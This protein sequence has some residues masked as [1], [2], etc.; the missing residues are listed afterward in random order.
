MSLLCINNNAFIIQSDWMNESL[1]YY[2]WQFQLAEMDAL[3]CINGKCLDVI[4]CGERNRHQGPDFLHAKIRYDNALWVGQVEMH[5]LSSDWFKHRHQH[6]ANYNNVILHVVWEHDV[7]DGFSFPTLELKPVVADSMLQLYRSLMSRQGFIAC[8]S[9]HTVVDSIIAKKWMERLMAERLMQKAGLVLEEFKSTVNHWEEVCWRFISRGFGGKVNG[10]AFY[11]MSRSIPW[12]LIRKYRSDRMKLESLLMGQL[13]L[14]STD[15][16]DEYVNNMKSSYEHL[17]KKHGLVQVLNALHFL[18]MRPSGFPT[19]RLS[20]LAAFIHAHESLM[21]IVL[22]LIRSNQLPALFDL[23]ASAYWDKH[24]V[25]GA[26]PGKYLVK[27]TGCHFNE[28]MLVNVA[29]PILFAFAWH[30]HD[31]EMKAKLLQMLERLPAESNQLIKEF[32]RIGWSC[33]N[34]LDSQ[35]LVQ[36]KNKYCDVKR[37]LECPVGNEL[38]KKGCRSVI[39]GN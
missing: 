26:T 2:I 19:I 25:I 8:E 4:S 12:Q 18:R 5:V 24:Y 23:Q 30:H 7:V 9:Y 29:A 27:N 16:S 20:Q 13:G 36:L 22:Q 11:Q 14:L 3:K 15:A 31:E 38:M 39:D 37:C 6:D 33:E 35:A 34:A 17:K 32:R 21:A 1:L 10:E 28:Y